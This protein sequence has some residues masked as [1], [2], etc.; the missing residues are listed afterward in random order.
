MKYGEIFLVVVLLCMAGCSAQKTEYGVS[1]NGHVS[2][3]LCERSKSRITDMNRVSF[4]LPVLFKNAPCIDWPDYGYSQSLDTLSVAIPGVI[5]NKDQMDIDGLYSMYFY[6]GTRGRQTFYL[7]PDVFFADHQEEAE[8]DRSGFKLVTS[9]WIERENLRC[10]R[11]YTEREGKLKL[12]RR[13]EYFCWESVSGFDSPFLVDASQSIPAGSHMVTNLDKELIEPV[14][15]SL[16]VNRASSVQLAQLATERSAYCTA[17]KSNYD[18]GKWAGYALS[19]FP[20]RRRVIRALSG[21]GYAMPD[22]V[23]INSYEELFISGD[24]LIGEGDRFVRHVSPEQFAELEQKLLSLHPRKLPDR[25]KTNTQGIDPKTGRLVTKYFFAGGYSG[26][27]YVIPPDYSEREG[28]GIRS[29]PVE[30][31]V[32]DIHMPGY[33]AGF[34]IVRD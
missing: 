33:E 29:D 2:Y 3:P 22:P 12:T 27:W 30:G 25:P 34:R 18:T 28:F 1:E 11:F 6:G 26:D 21:C 15:A 7:K 20:D 13:V 23:G 8:L 10:A 4:D 19:D 14:L 16:Q 5:A 31:R 32:I 9:S 24:H 17:L